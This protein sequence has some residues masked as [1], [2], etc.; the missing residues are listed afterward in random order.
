MVT[1][2]TE[3]GWRGEE[4]ARR[5]LECRGFVFIERNF[6]TRYGEIDLIMRDGGTTVF[7]EV[8]TRC[9]R[10]FGT[11]EESVG[12]RKI[13]KMATAVE[14]YRRRK[15]ETGPCRI[16]LVTLE[17]SNWHGRWDIRYTPNI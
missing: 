2:A 5:W 17:Y 7:I 13:E 12:E 8:K 1:R 15:A 16:D 3:L 4:V 14:E 10:A 6:R 9:G 11:P